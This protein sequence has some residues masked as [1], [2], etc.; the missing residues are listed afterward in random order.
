MM[1]IGLVDGVIAIVILGSTIYS[2]IKGFIKELFLIVAIVVGVL[3]ATKFYP[4]ARDFLLPWVH[5]LTISTLIGFF[6][7]FFL[8]AVLL[9][10]IGNIVSKLVHFLK[11]GFLDRI[12]GGVLGV[13]KG[14]LICGI[15]CMLILAFIPR[16][17]DLLKDSVLAPRI[18]SLTS[19]IFSLLPRTVWEKYRQRLRHLNTERG[20]VKG[21]TGAC[22]QL[23]N[24]VP[25]TNQ[26]LFLK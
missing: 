19:R 9:V 18:L 8:I 25:L 1:R 20:V 22:I 16:G 2:L 3:V 23:M 15:G 4:V 10:I 5:N 7:I 21:Q 14:I 6:L 11:L 12:L 17:E 13:L 26:V 24:E